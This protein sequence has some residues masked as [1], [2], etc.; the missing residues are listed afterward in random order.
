[1]SAA[2]ARIAHEGRPARRCIVTGETLPRERLVR[3]VV[4]PDGVVLPDVTERLPG[5]GLWLRATRSMVQTACAKGLFSKA[6]RARVTA[7]P[8]LADRVEALLAQ[9]CLDLLGLARRAG[10]AV[11]GF[12][13]VA[14]M[15]RGGAG[16]LLLEASDGAE[17][18]RRKIRRLAPEVPLIALFSAAELG[19]AMGREQSVHVAL[20]PGS[21]A[22][23][24]RLQAE[25][26][27]GF[28]G[29]PPWKPG[30]DKGE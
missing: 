17:D 27:A 25:R 18:G 20:A 12:E 5:R 16:A 24:L 9:R 14:G 26:L 13:K 19:G 8:D 7:P 30:H 23:R 22:D 6:A 11:A 1:V 29:A 3:F 4:D 28:R 2:A 15:L 10:Q 21:L